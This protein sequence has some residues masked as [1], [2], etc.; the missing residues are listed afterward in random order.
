MRNLLIAA[1]A[2]VALAIP[3]N[4]AEA[5][6]GG[7]HWRSGPAMHWQGHRPWNRPVWR[8]HWRG[9]PGFNR[10]AWRGH[11]R[12][13]PGLNRPGF[14]HPVWG[15]HP[16]WR[17]RHHPN[18]VVIGGGFGSGFGGGFGHPCRTLWF[19]GWGWRCGW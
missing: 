1:A 15:G 3:T 4:P 9:H 17:W 16:G 10:P 13:H 18:V 2:L 7:R 8:G 14:N 19:D 11:W 12:G 5:D 6:R